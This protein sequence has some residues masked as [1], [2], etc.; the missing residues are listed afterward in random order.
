VPGADG[1]RGQQGQDG[2]RGPQGLDGATGADGERGPQG[3]PGATGPQGSIGPQGPPG[4]FNLVDGNADGSVHTINNL[5]NY[6]MGI[7]SI[8]LGQN[9]MASGDFSV[10]QGYG[11]IASGTGSHAEGGNTTASGDYSHAEGYGT[12][13]SKWTSHAEGN[14]TVAEGEYAH[15]EGNYTLASGAAAHA[16]GRNTTASGAYS[17]AEG[18]ETV[19]S[20]YYSHAEGFYSNA[21]GLA[22]HAEGYRTSASGY[23]AHAEGGN[24]IASGDNSHAGN[25]LTIA[26][27]F[28]QTAIG[29]ANFAQGNPTTIVPT[30]NA[31]II[32]NGTSDTNRS[33]AFRFQFDGNAYSAATFHAGGADY[34]EMFEWQDGNP[35]N[36]D[37]VGYFVTIQQGFIRKATATDKYILGVVSATPSIVGDSKGTE[38][39]DTYQRDQFGRIIYEWI[40]EEQEVPDDEVK[41]E[42]PSQKQIRGLEKA[43]PERSKTQVKKQ[44]IRVYRPKIN[45]AYNP[46][47]TYIPRDQR[48]EWAPVGMMGKLIVRDDGS[49]KPDEFCSVYTGGIATASESGYLVLK[50]LDSNLIQI[51]AK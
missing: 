10:A 42:I 34:A 30:D 46:E 25:Y 28:A 38:W 33:N 2:E 22:S 49:C 27:G 39:H 1:E 8:A 6:D 16:E 12:I 11:T 13:A 15:A 36:E 7:Y 40:T 3:P 20:A 48:A 50:R 43:T 4:I 24:T 21:S 19:A 14:H 35:N 29:R 23:Y 26:Q 44:P 47:K 9:T 51:I 5:D 31:L 17:H 37:R 41:I 32:G 18:S 45:P